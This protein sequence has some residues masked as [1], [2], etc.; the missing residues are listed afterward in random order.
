[1]SQFEFEAGV[2][3]CLKKLEGPLSGGPIPRWQRKERGG[4]LAC[5]GKPF[6]P[7]Q[8]TSRSRLTLNLSSQTYTPGGK[9][10]KTPSKSPKK[11]PLKS[12]KKFGL[13]PRGDRFIPARPLVDCEWSHF[14][15][16]QG[17]EAADSVYDM[18]LEGNDEYQATMAEHLGT[19]STCKI[20]RFKSGAPMTKEGCIYYMLLC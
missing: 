7:L 14:Q 4:N 13:S 9:K 1:M 2:N 8:A 17:S 19:N 10:A 15:I 18:E 16:M 3:D 5:S 6:S 20:L 12:P 11:T